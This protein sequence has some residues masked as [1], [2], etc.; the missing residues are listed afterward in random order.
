MVV[1]I[2]LCGVVLYRRYYSWW[3]WRMALLGHLCAEALKL[4]KLSIRAF[5]MLLQAWYSFSVR[6]VTDDVVVVKVQVL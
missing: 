1:D 2:V 6:L 4:G 5:E 3:W